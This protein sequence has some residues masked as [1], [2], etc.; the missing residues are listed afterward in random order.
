MRIKLVGSAAIGCVMAAALAVAQGVPGV[1]LPPSPPGQAAVQLG[2]AWEK[3]AEGSRYKDGKW[4]LLDYSR[5]LLRGRKDIFGAGD[6]YGKQVMDGT[7]I[8]RAGA[9]DTTRLTTQVPLQIGGKTIQ[10]GVYNV[11]VDLKPGN[12][13]FVLNTQTIQEKYDPNEKVKLYGAY[14]YDAKFD[15][16]R[17]PMTVRA[18]D[19]SI[20]QFTIAFVNVSDNRATLTMAWEKTM[21]AIDVAVAGMK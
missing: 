3:T 2:G 21:A 11:F 16:L 5:P 1:K 18:T 6:E 20:E 19:A 8:W 15:I 4:V 9:N 12:W 17:A 14:N 7:A 10:P 13:T